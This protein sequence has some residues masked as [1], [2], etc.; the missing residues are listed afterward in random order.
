ML[1]FAVIAESI[2]GYSSDE[3]DSESEDEQSST[4][5]PVPHV[6]NLPFC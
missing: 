3:G 1:F 4:S 5:A 2:D 6:P